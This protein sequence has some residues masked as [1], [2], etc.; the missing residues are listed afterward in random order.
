MQQ[1]YATHMQH[2]RKTRNTLHG[3]VQQMYAQ[4]M[5]HVCKC[6]QVLAIG[7]RALCDL[8]A[9]ANLAGIVMRWQG[10]RLQFVDSMGLHLPRSLCW[11]L[12]FLH[13]VA[14]LVLCQACRAMCCTRLLYS[15]AVGTHGCFHGGRFTFRGPPNGRLRLCRTRWTGQRRWWWCKRRRQCLQHKHQA[16]LLLLIIIITTPLG[17]GGGGLLLL[18]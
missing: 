9:I 10:L 14:K 15:T 18:A 2:V 6:K 17:G 4:C 5:Q 12:C 13:H 11:C 1:T 7:A 3:E 16:G 8:F